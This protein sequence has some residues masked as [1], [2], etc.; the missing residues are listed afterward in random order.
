MITGY[1]E[2][3]KDIQILEQQNFKHLINK[4]ATKVLQLW[5]IK[6]IV[7]NFYILQQC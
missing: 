4:K 6:N 1:A 7:V 5:W 2:K 3:N